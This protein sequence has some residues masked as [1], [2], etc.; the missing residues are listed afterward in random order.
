[1]PQGIQK[2][3]CTMCFKCQGKESHQGEESE[4]NSWAE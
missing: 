2:M 3:Q 4:K 1:M